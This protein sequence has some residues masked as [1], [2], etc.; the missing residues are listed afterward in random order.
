MAIPVSIE[1]LLSGNVVEWARIE[2][3]K[4]WNP[5]TTLK[6]ICAF[7]NDID[8]WGGGYI[9]IGAEEKNGT[10]VRPINGLSLNAIDAIQKDILRYCKLLVPSYIPICQPVEF[11]GAMLIVIWVPGGY[12]R[13]YRC[14]KVPSGKSKEKT[15]YIRKMSSTIE[16]TD[17]DVKELMTLSNNIPFDDRMNMK[18]SI[19]DLKH[20]LIRNYLAQ[21]DSLLY[22]S[23]DTD[24]VEKLAE[25]LRIVSGP[26]EFLRP[27]NVGLL[28]FND[29]PEKY[30]PYTRI[31][32]VNIPDPTGQGM[33]ERIFSGPIDQQLRDVLSYI[34][35][36][37]IAE[38]IFKSSD[39][40]EAVRI[41]N[42]SYVAIEEFVSNA[43]YHKSYQS[44]DPITIRIEKEQIEI[45]S[46]PGPDRS[47]SDDD[48]KAYKLRS[49]RYRNR[50]IGDFLKDLNLVEGRN[51]G[52]P[53]AISAIKENGSPMPILLTDADRTFFSVV[54]PIHV[55]FTDA[56]NKKEKTT[57][58]K[59]R[60]EIKAL[61][62]SELAKEPKSL[63]SLY[64]AMGYSGS[65]SKTYRE[66]IKEL[67]E[68]K[69]ICYADTRHSSKNILCIN[70]K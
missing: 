14:P 26:P 39:R 4:G 53:T 12:D 59:N 65:P 42:Y 6:T 5:D 58:R 31:E 55:A 33:E 8:N 40:P 23:S 25:D 27:L 10:I 3:K 52:F 54:L 13:P 45:T 30:F 46:I 21:T 16:A 34:K 1:K 48:I 38:K 56:E 9:I 32:L 7:A 36:N 15:Y 44:Y 18:A 64:L 35:N 63:N 49:R 41:T 24:S 28:F 50:R 51:T 61:I 20:P 68:T 37:V 67:I 70:E 60:S 57:V 11:E 17:S 69:Q 29:D 47:I 19:K 22:K 62:L 66:V 43:V 2:F